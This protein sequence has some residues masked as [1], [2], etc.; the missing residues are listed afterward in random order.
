M[1]AKNLRREY[2]KK[3]LSRG[4]LKES[5]FDQFRKWFVDALEEQ[6]I[7]VNAMTLATAS[8]SGKPSCRMVL[9]KHFDESGLY[10]FTSYESRKARELKENPQAAALFF[11]EELERQVIVE[12]NVE[13]VSREISQAYFSKRPRGSQLGAWASHQDSVIPSREH[14]EQE[15]T[16]LEESYKAQEIPLPP[17]WGGFKLIPNRFEF[18]QGRED[19]LH[20]RFSY[21]QENNL[22]K[23][24][25]LSP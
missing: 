6:I 14:L 5:P 17:F 22:W 19:R 13:V 16:R 24:E 12:G 3:R 4:E 23:I 1:E 7:E 11:W 2:L 15:Y 25:R 10:F 8:I 21:T 18:W 20:D 9:M